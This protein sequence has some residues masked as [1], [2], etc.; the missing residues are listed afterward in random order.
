MPVFFQ[1]NHGV[2]GAQEICNV[3]N[4]SHVKFTALSG[5]WQDMDTRRELIKIFSSAMCVFRLNKAKIGLLGYAMQDMGD[6]NI[7]ETALLD[8]IGVSVVHIP[9][10]ELGDLIQSAPENPVNDII[11]QDSIKFKMDPGITREEHFN[12]GKIEWAV[13]QLIAKYKLQGW[14]QHFVAL[15]SSP[16]IP[17]MPFLAASKIMSEGIPYSAEGDVCGAVSGLVMN[18]VAG[19]STLSEVFTVDYAKD[20]VKE[21]QTAGI[22]SG[23]DVG[24]FEPDNYATRAECAKII[25]IIINKGGIVK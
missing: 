8:Q 6:F 20:S 11:T 23:N 21:M 22:V 5:H 17:L 4:R 24:N 16:R 14:C 25:Y 10:D 19:N 2:H 9:L 18:M 7:D 13:R 15:G 12:A 3:L 1:E